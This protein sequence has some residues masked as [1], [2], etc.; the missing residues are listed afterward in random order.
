MKKVFSM[1]LALCFCVSCIHF[2]AYADEDYP[3]P[4]TIDDAMYRSLTATNDIESEYELRDYQ[5]NVNI[6]LVDKSI[7]YYSPKDEDNRLYCWPIPDV[8]AGATKK[9]EIRMKVPVAV[10]EIVLYF[11]HIYSD[12]SADWSEERTFHITDITPSDD[13]Q[14]F[15]SGIGQQY[16][17]LSSSF[18][19]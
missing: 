12:G 10:N 17:R 13:F 16:K 4:D 2:S 19:E 5:Q 1:I 8:N 9:I 7:V 15:T 14:S 3:N 11:A 6:S 18:G